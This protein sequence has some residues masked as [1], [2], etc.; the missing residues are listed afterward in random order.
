M[1]HVC[2]CVCVCVCVIFVALYVGECEIF[3]APQMTVYINIRMLI[4]NR[5]NVPIRKSSN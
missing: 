4:H 3:A 2:V 5:I 1:Y